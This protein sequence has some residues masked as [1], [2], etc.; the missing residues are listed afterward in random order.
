MSW[1][2]AVSDNSPSKVKAKWGP[3]EDDAG[4]VHDRLAV[5]GAQLVTRTVALIERGDIQPAA[6]DAALAT[7]APKIFK[8]HC[9]IRWDLPSVHVHNLVRG[10]SPAPGA[11]CLHDGRVLKIYRT[12]VVPARGKGTPGTVTVDADGVSVMT[13]DQRLLILELQQEGRRRMT[14]DEFLRGY[15][16]RSGDMLC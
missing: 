2:N 1:T 9:R 8:E 4:S 11:W 13:A 3:A 6:Q 7:P 12:S 10:L 14:V 15:P 16:L 5:L